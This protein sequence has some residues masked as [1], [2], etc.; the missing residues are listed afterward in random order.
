[1]I[2]ERRWVSCCAAAISW[3]SCGRLPPEAPVPPADEQRGR[4]PGS[5]CSRPSASGRSET[6][7][8]SLICVRSAAR[9]LMRIIGRPPFC[10]ARP[11]ATAAV[12][13]RF[14]GFVM[15]RRLRLERDLPERVEALDGRAESLLERLREAVHARGAAAQ[16][17]AIDAI[18]GRRRLEEIECLLDLEED[19][20]GHRVQDRTHLVEGD[21]LD[22]FALLQEL[23]ALE[24][25]VELFLDRLGIGVAAR[26]RCRA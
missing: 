11:T 21:A 2:E 25:E 6:S 20:L 7:A 19:V 17:D 23:R 3:S 1:M 22:R 26:S 12:A 5:G 13:T 4:P 18:G 15:P 16:H 14:S 24:R 10:S 9:R 8:S